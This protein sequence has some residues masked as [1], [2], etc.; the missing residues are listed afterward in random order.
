[1]AGVNQLAKNLL[2]KV[3]TGTSTYQDYYVKSSIHAVDGLLGDDEKIVSSLLP[4]WLVGGMKFIATK[5]GT[6]TL[7]GLFNDIESW[8]EDKELSTDEPYDEFK[9]KYFVVGGSGLTLTREPQGVHDWDYPD[10]GSGEQNP[11]EMVLEPGDWVVYSHYSGGIHYFGFVNNTYRD[12]REN[13]AGVI[14]LATQAEA[15]AGT[16]DTKAMT[17][18]KVKAFVDNT[19]LNASNLSGTVNDARLSSN[20]PRKNS[21]NVFSEKNTFNNLVVHNAGLGYVANVKVSN[22]A[23][24]DVTVYL[25]EDDGTLALKSQIDGLSVNQVQLPNRVYAG[26]ISGAGN[27]PTF[28]VLDES[29][30]PALAMSKI[31]GLSTALSGKANSSHSH[32]FEDVV[33]STG[34]G[35]SLKTTLT[36]IISDIAGKVPITRTINGKAL[37]SNITLTKSDISLGSVQNYGIASQDEAKKDASTTS[38][39]YM[40]P[41]RTL[42]A[43]NYWATISVYASE[44]EIPSDLPVGKLVFV[45]V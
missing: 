43:I 31:S 22:S 37:S 24:K 9:G 42:D 17:P 21:E 40:T 38:N 36:N 44:G 1:M 35:T 7:E 30:I 32:S 23:T 27:F 10:D 39:K 5:S 15:L 25:P 45:E 34:G 3:R 41:Q 4:S 13:E 19:S 11:N 14:P 28:R 12:A 6:A 29:D 16:N 8:L 18:K 20:I 2:L 33:D 26:P